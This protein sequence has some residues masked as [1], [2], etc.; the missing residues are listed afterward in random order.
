MPLPPVNDAYAIRPKPA[1]SV[2]A[3]RTNGTTIVTVLET[4]LIAG[5]VLSGRLGGA[6]T[7][8]GGMIGNV[9]VHQAKHEEIEM[10]SEKE[11][12]SSYELSLS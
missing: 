2:T 1:I 4:R 10:N 9:R 7:V 5:V 12:G 6:V 11:T 8:R 3:N